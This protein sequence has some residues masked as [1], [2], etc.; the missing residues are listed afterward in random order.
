MGVTVRSTNNIPRLVQI[1]RKLEHKSIKVGVFGADNYTYGNDADL[2]TV[3]RVQ[4]FGATIKPVTAQ[5]LTL[6]LIHAAKNKRAGDFP[7]L[8]FYKPNGANHAFL[9]R[10]LGHGQVENVF[11][12]VKE[13]TVPERS[14]LRTGFDLNVDKICNKI[15]DLLNDVLDFQINPRLFLEGIGAEFTEMIQ[16][17]MRTI[18]TPPNSDITKNVKQ[19]SNPLHD[20][21]RLIGAI[22]HKVE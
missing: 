3:A 6:P 5:W 12:L 4:E 8:F 22:R 18:T 7:D 11:L 21:G 19:S 20:T 1:L 10:D 14:F 13:V 9:A 2:V 17:H 15:E 16:H